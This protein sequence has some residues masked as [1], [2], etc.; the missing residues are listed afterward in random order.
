MSKNRCWFNGIL[1]EVIL[2]QRNLTANEVLALYNRGL[3]SS[4]FT[5]LF[6]PQPIKFTL[7]E[8]GNRIKRNII[9]LKSANVFTE[10]DSTGFNY[11]DLADP[12]EKFEDNLGDRKVVILP[13][14]TKGLLSVEIIGYEDEINT[15]LYLY[16]LSGKLLISKM[17]ANIP[18]T[19]DLNTYPSGIYIL[20][21]KL[22]D[23]VS[24]W[25]IV[26]E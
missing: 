15:T 12:D 5:E 22:C 25:K 4:D 23:K 24:E 3:T 18:I 20:K 10:T 6:A 7:D 21:I 8:F 16:N 9:T 19:L 1:D 13:N 14:P 11:F 26:K 2:Y 17:P